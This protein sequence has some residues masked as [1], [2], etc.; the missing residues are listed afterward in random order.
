MSEPIVLGISPTRGGAQTVHVREGFELLGKYFSSDIRGVSAAYAE[1]RALL[2]QGL[3]G[4]EEDEVVT[5]AFALSVDGS[6]ATIT[7][8]YNTDHTATFATKD[9]LRAFDEYAEHMAARKRSGD[10]AT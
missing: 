9:V 2:E 5:D 7:L 6:E 10:S 4:S 8:I 3:K 1:A